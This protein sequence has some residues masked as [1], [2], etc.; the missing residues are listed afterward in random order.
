V[1][2]AELKKDL[3]ELEQRLLRIRQF[4]LSVLHE[5]PY[6]KEVDFLKLSF[7]EIISLAQSIIEIEERLEDRA[8][9]LPPQPLTRKAGQP[10]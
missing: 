9:S 7:D 1:T 10:Y 6:F 2:T 8:R 3:A 4:V 5:T